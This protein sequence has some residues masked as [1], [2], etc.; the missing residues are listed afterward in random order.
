MQPGQRSLLVPGGKSTGE[1]VHEGLKI[2]CPSLH[3]ASD[4]E[5]DEDGD[6]KSTS[7]NS[8]GSGEAKGNSN[9]KSLKSWMSRAATKSRKGGVSNESGSSGV[10]GGRKS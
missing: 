1:S 5:D 3:L 6:T 8:N 4:D 7:A 9:G 10:V 2:P